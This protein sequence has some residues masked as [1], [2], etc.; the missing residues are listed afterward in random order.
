MVGDLRQREILIGLTREQVV[1]LLGEPNRDAETY[2]EYF[3]VYGSTLGFGWMEKLV[4]SFDRDN[5]KVKF[6]SMVD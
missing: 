1:A 6:V 5:G 4:I 3:V 2:M